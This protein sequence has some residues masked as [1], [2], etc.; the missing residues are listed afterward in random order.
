MSDTESKEPLNFIE[1]IIE[2]DLKNGKHGGVVHTRF[3]PEPNGYPHIGHAKSIVLNFGLAEK[4]GGKC[5]LRFDDTN[6]EK[7]SSEYV[8]AI[9][10][11]VEWLGYEWHGN[12]L[13]ASDYFDRLYEWATELI[14]KEKAYVDDTPVE[15]IRAERGTP[16]E[17]GKESAYRNRSV[18]E[19][20]T[21][22][23]EMKDGKYP[24][25]AKILRAK[26]DMASPNMHMRDPILYRIRHVEHHRTGNSWC[27]YP[28]YDFAHGQSDSLEE[29]THSLCTLEFEVHRPLYNWIIEQLEIFPSRQIEF[30]R[31]NLGY[32]IVS[33]RKLLQLVEGGY[34]SGWDD[35]RMP[36]LSG[37]RRRG[38]TPNAIKNFIHKVGIARRD[39]ITD[40]ALLEYS[41]REDLNKTTN[42]VMGVLDPVKLTITNYPEDRDEELTAINNPEDESAGTRKLPF[43]NEIFIER[44]DFMEDPPRKFF[45]LGPGREVRLKYAYIIKCEDFKKDG[46]GNITEIICT[47][48]PDSKSGQDTSGKKVKGTLSWVSAKHAETVEVRLYDR[49]FKTENLN[50]IEDDFLNHLNTDSLSTLDNV[51]VEPSLK[52]AQAGS[53]FQFERQGY[54]VVDQDSGDTK[55]IFNRTVTLRD[56][57][58]KQSRK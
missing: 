1:Q 57:W 58:A 24:D 48:D 7:E 14:K 6:P 27:I 44:A 12:A 41:I 2:E 9:K 21:L 34:V 39:S 20:L 26:V 8:E 28:T 31:L 17:P 3:P 43:S 16:T 30:A 55:K 10:R 51:K 5:N 49:L 38:Y 52:N 32:T 33:K 22:F 18:E 29:I 13:F 23:S 50:E 19:N 40:V 54:F 56:N 15:Q 46:D 11:D 37:I 35:P 53:R 36:T 45:R 47:Y 4:Y 25:G 42:R